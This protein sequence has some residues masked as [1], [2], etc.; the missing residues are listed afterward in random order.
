MAV[1]AMQ[2][3]VLCQVA[4]GP[5]RPVV[6]QRWA[7][8]RKQVEMR[9]QLEPAIGPAAVPIENG[10]V[11]IR[12]MDRRRIIR[13]IERQ[14][15]VR[16]TGGKACQPW[17]QPQRQECRYAGDR[18]RSGFRRSCHTRRGSGDFRKRRCY[19]RQQVG[20]V[21]GQRQPLSGAVEQ[22]DLQRRF[23]RLDLVTDRAM[24][25]AK[26]LGRLGQERFRAVASKARSGFSGGNL[27]VMGSILM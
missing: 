5:D 1:I 11:D 3:G 13:R 17:H 18:Q 16:I 27:W 19:R 7:G 9:P 22:L 14:P 8:D 25:H 20:P 26:F 23:E 12:R 4:R 2:D 15:D 6:D 21:L 10:Y 24:G